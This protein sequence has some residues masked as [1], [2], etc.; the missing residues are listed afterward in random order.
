M[1]RPDMPPQ[2]AAMKNFRGI[3]VCLDPYM[4]VVLEQT[5]EYYRGL[6]IKKHGDT[7]IRGNNV[8]YLSADL[9]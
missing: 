9:K 2:L 3:L 6:L 4:N 7:F 8:L 5:E 1:P